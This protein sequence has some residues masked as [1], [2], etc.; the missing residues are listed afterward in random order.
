MDENNVVITE[1]PID[2]KAEYEKQK[3]RADGLEIEVGK[4]KGLKDKYASENAEYKRKAEAQMSEEE[5]RAKEQQEMLTKYQEMESKVA[6]MELKEKLLTNGFTAEE[7]EKLI[8][9]GLAVGAVEQIAEII[10]ARVDTAVK[11]VEAGQTKTSTQSLMGKGSADGQGAKSDFQLHQES[12]KKS[13]N[14]VDLG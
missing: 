7:S 8:K 5:K 1:T 14:V 6:Q 9:S 2:Y 11:S 10:K 3:A 12:K 4:Q 13:S